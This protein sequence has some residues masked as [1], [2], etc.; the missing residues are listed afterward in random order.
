MKTEGMDTVREERGLI[1]PAKDAKEIAGASG[2]YQGAYRGLPGTQRP[3]NTQTS[4]KPNK[5]GG[6]KGGK[7]IADNATIVRTPA[8]AQTKEAKA[9]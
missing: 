9:A 1:K 8:Q 4:N 6:K 2:P 3:E 5:K 7:K